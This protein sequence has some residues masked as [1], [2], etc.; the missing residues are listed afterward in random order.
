MANTSILETPAPFGTSTRATTRRPL[1]L[2]A[3]WGISAGVFIGM[4]SLPKS[5]Q[6]VDGCLVLLCFAAPSWSAIPQCVPPIKQ[7][8]NDLAHGRPFPTCAMSGTGNSAT[9]KRSS[10][11]A[12]CPP[13]YSRK[14][15]YDGNAAE[16]CEF[17]GAVEVSIEG[18][19][20]T[21][22]W[23]SLSGDSVTEYTPAAK[24]R[25]GT[26]D[27]RFDDDYARWLAM[28]PPALPS[29]DICT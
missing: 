23:W 18:G 8:L 19:L 28:Q 4:A 26:F 1:W 2:T 10:A 24:A 20:W 9:N 27:T 13:Q 5:A 16:M 12:Y 21:R 11:P 14:S 6:A 7:V 29:C 22:T 17:D 3:A 25:L 15:E